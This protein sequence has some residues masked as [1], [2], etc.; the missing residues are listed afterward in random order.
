M[1]HE[2]RHKKVHLLLIRE[3]EREVLLRASHVNK[4]T[5]ALSLSVSLSLSLS[6]SFL[7]SRFET[8]RALKRAFAGK[9][10]RANLATFGYQI[11]IEEK[12]E[13]ERRA[14]IHTRERERASFNVF[15]LE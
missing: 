14:R 1:A 7:F 13:R 15:V 12:K 5:F 6:V 3:H 8:K 10:E 2:N 9:T 4:K 11:W